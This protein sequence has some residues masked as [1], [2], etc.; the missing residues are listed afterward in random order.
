MSSGG[1]FLHRGWEAWRAARALVDRGDGMES[2]AGCYVVEAWRS[3]A[4]LGSRAESSELV[5]WL[6]G[7]EEPPLVRAEWDACAADLESRVAP[8]DGSWTAVELEVHLGRLAQV[9][10][11]RD[12]WR[13]RA[14]ARWTRRIRGTSAVWLAAVAVV[15]LG[16][17]HLWDAVATGDRWRVAFYPTARLQGEPTVEH[18]AELAFV[19]RTAAPATGIPEDGFS[20][21][22]DTCL[23]AVDTTPVVFELDADDGARV[24]VDDK[25][26]LDAW[27]Y[28]QPAPLVQTLR[29]EP[30]T[31]HLIVEAY[32]A[33]DDAALTLNLR[34][35]QG[36][37]LEETLLVHPGDGDPPCGVTRAK[38]RE[39]EEPKKAWHADFFPS[40]ELT[41]EPI[42]AELEWIT[43][44]W[45][46]RGPAPGVPRDGFSARFR[47]CLDMQASE[48][49]LVALESDDGARVYVDGS[50][51]AD[52]WSEG[53]S[54]ASRGE[55]HAARGAHL[56]Q[57][58]YYDGGG[59]AALNVRLYR[60]AGPVGP[61]QIRFPEPGVD[62]TMCGW[63]VPPPPS[64]APVWLVET[65]G[66]SSWAPRVQASSEAVPVRWRSCLELVEP[67]TLELRMLGSGD[68]SIAVGDAS[69]QGPDDHVFAL[70]P[71]V[72]SVVLTP[73][74]TGVDEGLRVEVSEAQTLWSELDGRWLHA[75]S[76]ERGVHHC[77]AR[78]KK[79]R[80]K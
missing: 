53:T 29:V 75:P 25:L 46:N 40:R 15:V 9:L 54:Q 19:W 10:S 33:I 13:T 17:G 30:G 36:E 77:R 44:D 6:R 1:E 12:P 28:G 61:E 55:V 76:V 49:V 39:K 35:E 37:R 21:R 20:V 66:E 11:A 72:H 2:V 67:R 23:R 78:A 70:E 38:D 56:I 50:L 5:A 18:A 80:G 43:H 8:D 47:T 16:G 45:G 59:R 34:S 79:G 63:N 73:G 42:S 32:E 48:R 69:E 7:R 51:V 4:H 31:H 71:G 60:G 68:A 74:V 58:D 24:F 22:A 14:L 3:V 27:D 26:V 57:V 64:G 65:E 62:G 41:G 52:T